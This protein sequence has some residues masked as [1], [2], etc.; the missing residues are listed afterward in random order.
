MPKEPYFL[1]LAGTL[2]Y[3]AT[4][5][6]TLFLGWN[7]RTEWPTSSNFVNSFL[8]NPETAASWLGTLEQIQLG[9]GAVIISFLG[10]IHWVC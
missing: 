7:V 2:P 4:S 5:I 6:S 10:A 8:L 1:G 3:L 9:Y